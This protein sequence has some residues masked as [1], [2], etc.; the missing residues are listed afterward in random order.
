MNKYNK[1]ILIRNNRP[2]SIA[3]LD[4]RNPYYPSITL[5]KKP[6][7]GCRDSMS[8]CTVLITCRDRVSWCTVLITCRDRVSWCTV[9]ITYRD[10]GVVIGCRDGPFLYDIDLES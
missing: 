2:N 5:S 4:I 10:E 8:W 1:V 6:A 9:L 3:T 7:R